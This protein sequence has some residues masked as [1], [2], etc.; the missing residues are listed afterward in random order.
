VSKAG[1]SLTWLGLG[2]ALMFAWAEA[3]E[4]KKIKQLQSEVMKKVQPG[5]P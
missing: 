3:A 4:K 1:S 2:I 5:G